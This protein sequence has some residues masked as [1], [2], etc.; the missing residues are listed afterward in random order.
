MKFY[1]LCTY[2]LKLWLSLIY[3]LYIS[4][5]YIKYHIRIL[6]EWIKCS[7]YKCTEEPTLVQL[8][9]TLYIKRTKM[10]R[11]LMEKL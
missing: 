3:K 2:S 4:V 1:E 5:I 6:L 11:F 10:H 8:L 7:K 9:Y